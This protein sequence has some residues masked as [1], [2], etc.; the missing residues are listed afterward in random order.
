MVHAHLR[1]DHTPAGE[2]FIT[3]GNITPIAE[4]K[5]ADKELSALAGP[6]ADPPPRTNKSFDWHNKWTEL[7]KAFRRLDNEHVYAE[8]GRDR[9]GGEIWLLGCD[10][11]GKETLD[12]LEALCDLAGNTLSASVPNIPLSETTSSQSWKRWLSHVRDL[13]GY[14]QPT[15]YSYG[16]GISYEGG[17]IDN[18]AKQS[19]LVCIKCRGTTYG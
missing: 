10:G 4:A 14:T 2:P 3:L 5:V 6:M 15:I 1:P 17:K 11:I 16:K 12:E 7:Q 18:P 9:L 19:A 8:N 13:Q